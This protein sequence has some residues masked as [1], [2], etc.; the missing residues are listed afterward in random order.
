M[1]FGSPRLA[2][3][4]LLLFTSLLRAACGAEPMVLCFGADGHVALEASAH[5]CN[6]AA[7]PSS[8][9]PSCEGLADGFCSGPCRDVTVS[10][11]GTITA[12]AGTAE[13][14]AR[15]AA[16]ASLPPVDVHPA[17]L[18]AAPGPPHLVGFSPGPPASPPARSALRTTILLI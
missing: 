8:E 1:T 16:L 5:D 15:L 7:H 14:L 6:G 18:A 10:F 4:C 11:D 9:G 12:R 2:T 17:S 3:L 13:T